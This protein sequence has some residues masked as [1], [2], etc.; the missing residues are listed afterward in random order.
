MEKKF[1]SESTFTLKSR[2]DMARVFMGRAYPGFLLVSAAVILINY[3][4][5]VTGRSAEG[6][7]KKTAS[8]FV[9]MVIWALIP[10]VWGFVWHKKTVVHKQTVD[11]YT[12][13]LVITDEKGKRELTPDRFYGIV[14]KE[15]Y[16]RL[17]PLKET[18]I[19]NKNDVTLGDAEEIVRFLYNMKS[20]E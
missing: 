15:D 8:L 12:D 13:R 4:L 9:L 18:V 1:S 7:V 3:Y 20:N 19:I 10:V 17:G 2:I 6:D 5:I 11:I 16:I 14:E